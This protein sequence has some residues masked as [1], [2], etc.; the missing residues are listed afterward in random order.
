MSITTPSY[1][2]NSAYKPVQFGITAENGYPWLY[3][4]VTNNNGKAQFTSSGFNLYGTP[5][6][7]YLYIASGDYAGI[8]VIT[9][10]DGDNIITNT[11]FVATD[12]GSAVVMVN[13]KF[14]VWYGY[15][16]QDSYIDLSPIWVSGNL[17]VDIQ[18]VLKSLFTIQPPVPGYDD[19][20]Y[21][22][23]KIQIIAADDYA[24]WLEDNSLVEADV[25]ESNTTY[26]WE[27]AAN[28]WYVINGVLPHQDLNN[29]IGE[30]SEYIL[31]FETPITTPNQCSIVSKIIEDRVFNV[32]MCFGSSIPES[33]IVTPLELETA[34]LG[35]PYS[36]SFDAT[37]GTGIYVSFTV[38]DGSLPSWLF[39]N[40]NT[41]AY[42]GTPTTT[43]EAT[44]TIKVT[45]NL[46]NYG[47][48][49]YTLA[50]G[51]TEIVQDWLDRGGT[52]DS[53]L[54]ALL[55]EFA[56][57]IDPIRAKMIRVNLWADLD[58]DNLVHP[59]I[60]GDGT[61][62]YG[63][64][65]DT[66]VNFVS[67]DYDLATGLDGNGTNKAW[68]TSIVPATEGIPYNDMGM[69]FFN[70]TTG[71]T[72][73]VTMG[74]YGAGEWTIVA[75]NTGGNTWHPIGQGG[76]IFV[77]VGTDV[78]FIFATRDGDNNNRLY[79]DSTNTDTQ[80]A[81]GTVASTQEINLFR[82]DNTAGIGGYEDRVLR[83]YVITFGLDAT[84][85]EILSDAINAFYAAL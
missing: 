19:N 36:G 40:T 13:Y 8:H 1:Q 29:L 37:G 23:F 34:P 41:G 47:T 4:A 80:V 48:R 7:K 58:F 78:G 2:W 6:G 84:E 30:T 63:S 26:D 24:E 69:G 82:S 12:S 76:N 35:S 67:G 38:V 61:T 3:T 46:G 52:A 50:Y 66:N 64:P 77:A 62:E 42:S 25:I 17:I 53:A 68:R 83:G 56:T 60:I 71:S 44:F 9:G 59:L 79:V 5:P 14:R 18:E 75:A 16:T 22:H 55:N 85:E 51:N 11:P 39:L 28:K 27:L 72:G 10:L 73:G 20:M 70:A 54:L 49:E 45:D 33:L 65:T 74:A 81:A 32:M 43:G 57:A 21:T 15:P 31:S